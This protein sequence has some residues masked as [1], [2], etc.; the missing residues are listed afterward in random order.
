MISSFRERKVD[1]GHGGRS[2]QALRLSP[3]KRSNIGLI[4]KYMMLK[5][6]RKI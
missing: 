3:D 1:T 5:E 2:R 4:Y 6:L